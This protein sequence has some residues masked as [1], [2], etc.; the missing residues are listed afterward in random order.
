[1]EIFA[2]E[3]E[4]PEMWPLVVVP[5]EQEHGRKSTFGV[6]T[7]TAENADERNYSVTRN[8]KISLNLM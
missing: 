8:F 6:L 7:A 5:M 1:M 2:G 3:A 4:I